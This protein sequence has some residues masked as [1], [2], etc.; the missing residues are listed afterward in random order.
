MSVDNCRTTTVTV[1]RLSPCCRSAM[2][3]G[4]LCQKSITDRRVRSLSPVGKWSR[5]SPSVGMSSEMP[6]LDDGSIGL[7]IQYMERL[8]LVLFLLRW[9]PCLAPSTGTTNLASRNPMARPRIGVKVQ[10][11]AQPT[12]SSRSISPE[13]L[14]TTHTRDGDADP[15]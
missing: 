9:S 15:S 12:R 2:V 8:E 4:L 10:L 11:Q 6:N 14:Q 5:S 1:L 13:P 7:S 3:T